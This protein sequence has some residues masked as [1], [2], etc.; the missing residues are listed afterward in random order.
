[1]SE[2]TTGGMKVDAA[3]RPAGLHTSHTPRF[4]Y[5]SLNVNFGCIALCF[6][7]VMSDESQLLQYKLR[8]QWLCC[9]MPANPRVLRVE[10]YRA[11]HSRSFGMSSRPGSSRPSN[12]IDSHPSVNVCSGN[13]QVIKWKPLPLLWPRHRTHPAYMHAQHAEKPSGF[14]TMLLHIYCDIEC[15][16]AVCQDS[17]HCP[18]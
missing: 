10:T 3:G 2:S 12:L 5:I 6:H 15:S 14:S 8:V 17:P 7:A 16:L 18:R 11:C 13:C 9:A 1:M 4:K